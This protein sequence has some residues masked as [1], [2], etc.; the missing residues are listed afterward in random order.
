MR[1]S[2]ALIVLQARMGS[3]RLPGKVL[4]S[5][6]GATVLSRCV[7]RLLAEET[8]PLVVATTERPEDDAVQNEAV[9]LGV[10]CLRGPDADV[11]AR[12]A[13]IVDVLEPAYVLRATADNPAVDIEAPGRILDHL[14]RGG[15]DYVAERG[16]PVGAAVEGMRAE[17]LLRAAREA[18]DPADREHVTPYIKQPRN[19]FRVLVPLAPAMLRAPELRLTVDTA[20]DFAFLEAVLTQ[21]GGQSVGVPL[22]GIIRAARRVEAR[23][24]AA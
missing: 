7:E 5:I 14:R 4:R 21:A 10:P 17:A 13:R 8:A 18:V 9:R 6:A 19:R 23:R 11:L 15:V 16:L 12:F 24:E 1:P 2:D 3:T 20:E 22:C